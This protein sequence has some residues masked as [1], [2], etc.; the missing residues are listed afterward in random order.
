MNSQAVVNNI[1][2]QALSDLG[3]NV[4]GQTTNQQMSVNS[5]TADLDKQ[6][7]HVAGCDSPSVSIL[8][9]P[10]S[11]EHDFAKPLTVAQT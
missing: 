3:F 10:K 9:G 5:R 11:T 2:V 8:H 6:I 1:R 4:G 7:F